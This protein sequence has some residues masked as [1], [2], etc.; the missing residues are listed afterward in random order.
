MRIYEWELLA[1]CHYRD[2]FCDIRHYDSGG[3]TSLIYH[4]ATCLKGH[5]TISIGAPHCKFGSHRF[6]VQRSNFSLKVVS[7]IIAKTKP[8]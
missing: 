7:N 5:V 8:K 2:K 1:V 4:V 3:I 6:Y